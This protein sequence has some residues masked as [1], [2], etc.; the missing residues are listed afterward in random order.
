VN[1]T[2]III[3]VLVVLLAGGGGAAF[4]MMNNKSEAGSEAAA[5]VAVEEKDDPIFLELNPPFVVNYQHEGSLRYLQTSI[6]L[7]HTDQD[8][9]DDLTL[10]MPIIRNNL[11]MILSEQT[12][13][14]LKT[15]DAKEVLRTRISESVD[16]VA[17]GKEG[18]SPPVEVYIT[19]F[20]M[21]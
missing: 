20:V 11:I 9:I 1:K 7:M 10:R 2:I 5:E 19:K 12:F 14:D 15:R 13:D 6:Q 17:G 8:V 16:E 4:F 3:I 18:L 21:Q